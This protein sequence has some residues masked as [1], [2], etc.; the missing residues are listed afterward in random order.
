M[1]T[2]KTLVLIKPDGIMKRLTGEILSRFERKGLKIAA[3]KML[4]VSIDIAE[5]HYSVHKGKPFYGSLIEYIT[6]G[7]VVAMVLEGDGAIAVVRKMIGSTD[8]SKAEPG[9]IRGDFAMSVNFNTV[10]ASDSAE[11]A[12]YEIPI[13]FKEQEVLKYEMPDKDYI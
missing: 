7:P 6:S 8:G 9:T 12:A 4:N 11:S 1:T 3:I 10:H 13:F 2:E 5:K